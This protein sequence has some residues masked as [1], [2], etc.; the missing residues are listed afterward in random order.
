MYQPQWRDGREI[1]VGRRDAA[2]RYTAILRHLGTPKGLR[3]LD[4]GAYGGYFSL[5]LLHD[6][7]L[8]CTAVDDSA[9]LTAVQEPGLTAINRRLTPSELAELGQFDAALCLSV[10]HHLPDWHDYLTVLREAA[11]L[12]YVETAHPAESLPRAVAH[13]HSQ[14]ITDTIDALG[15]TIIAH[16]PG[17]D[18]AHD[19]PLWVLDQRPPKRPR[20]RATK[21]A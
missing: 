8:A 10:L 12:L 17:Y 18:A 3:V 14:A 1:G 13:S 19:R 5:R 7:A 4:F 11:P 20:R 2:G 6:G 9:A 16:T 21:T 15:G